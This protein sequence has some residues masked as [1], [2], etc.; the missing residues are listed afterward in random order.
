LKKNLTDQTR[1]PDKVE[2]DSLEEM[3]KRVLGNTKDKNRGIKKFLESEDEE[4][5]RN[6]K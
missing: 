2:N 3:R 5:N 4:A 6:G 1:K